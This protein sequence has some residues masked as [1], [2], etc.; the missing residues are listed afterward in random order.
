MLCFFTAV[1][2]GIQPIREDRD[3][4]FELLETYIERKSEAG[5][6]E[7][8]DRVRGLVPHMRRRL[9][10]ASSKEQAWKQ[11]LSPF[12]WFRRENDKNIRGKKDS[13]SASIFR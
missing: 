13:S 12:G 4:A 10:K 11:P 9:W 7:D 8:Y 1:C 2:G 5:V 3:R 6:R